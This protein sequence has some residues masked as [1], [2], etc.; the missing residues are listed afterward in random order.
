MNRMGSSGV[1][2]TAGLNYDDDRLMGPMGHTSACGLFPLPRPDALPKLKGY[3]RRSQHRAARRVRIR[4]DLREAIASLNWMHV[5]DFDAPPSAAHPLQREVLCRL[6]AL[7]ERADDLGDH[8]HLPSLEAAYGELLRGRDGYAE[9]STPASLAPYNLELVSLPTDLCDA[10]RAEELLEEADRRYLQG[11]ERMLREI[12]KEDSEVIKPYWDPALRHNPGR[13]RKFIQRLNDIKYLDFT[14]SPS[15]HAGVFFVWKSDGKRIRMI[16]DARPANAE[17]EEP[18]GISLP[19]A[20]TFAK[21]EMETHM[22][23][24]DDPELGI[25]AGLSDVRDCFHRIKQPR[26]L[27]KYFCF[28]PIEAKHVGLTGTVLE[29]H[30]LS[31]NDLV[32]PMPGSLCMG[33]SWSLFFAQRIN[34][35]VMRRVSSLSSSTLIHDRGGPAVFG[36]HL[37]DE[38]KHF[39]YVDNLGVM[40]TDR[41][42]VSGALDDL[43]GKFT[44]EKLLLHPG[45]IQHECIKALGVQLD[46]QNLFSSLSPDRYHRVRQ[47]LRCLL[48]RGRCSGRVLEILIGHCTYCG[49]MNRALLSVF[50]NVYKFIHS[51]HDHPATLW[52]SVRAELRAFCGLMPLIASDWCRPWN[53]LV[54][55]SDASEEGFGV[56]AAVWT[57]SQ[58]AAV[59]RVSERD[60]FK[61]AGSHSARETALTSAGFVKDE[62]SGK[63]AE[64]ILDDEEYLKLSGWDLRTDFPEVPAH[65][66][67]EGSWQTVRQGRWKKHE[68]IVHLEARALVKSFEYLVEDTHSKDCRQL[69]LVDSMSAALAFDRCRSR[70]F[71]MLRQIRKFCSYGLARNISFSVRWVASELNPADEP[72]RSP[73]HVVKRSDF[74]GLRPHALHHAD[75]KK[76]GAATARG[77]SKPKEKMCSAGER[78]CHASHEESQDLLAPADRPNS[79][80]AEE[81]VLLATQPRVFGQRHGQAPATA[82]ADGA[83]SREC[84]QFLEFRTCQGCQNQGTGEAKSRQAS[85]VCARGHGGK[86]H[87]SQLVRKESHWG[88][89]RQVLPRGVQAVAHFCQD[90]EADDDSP[91]RTGCNPC[92]VLQRPFHEGSP[93]ASGGQNHRH[94]DAPPVR[95]QQAGIQSAAA[96]LAMSQRLEALSARNLEESLSPRRV[97]CHRLG[98]EEAGTSSDG[99]LYAGGPLFVQPSFRTAEM[100]GLQPGEAVARDYRVLESFAE[101]RRK[102]GSVESRRVRRQHCPRLSLDEALG[103][104]P[105]EAAR[106]PGRRPPLVELQLLPLLQGFLPGDR[107]FGARHDTISD[108]AQRAFNRSLK[109]PA[110]SS[111]GPEKRKVAVAQKCGQI[112]EECSPGRNLPDASTTSPTS[113]PPRRKT[114]RGCDVGPGPRLASTYKSKGLKGQYVADLFAGKGGVAKA[115]R[116][117]GYRAKEWEL[118]RGPQFDLTKRSVLRQLRLDVQQGLILA[119]MLAPPCSSFSIA[120]DR[121][122]V[123]RT[124][125]HPWGLPDHMLSPTDQVKV[126]LGN[127]CF[128]SALKIIS[129]LD[130]QKIPWIL[131][132]PFTSKCW[133]LPPIRKLMQSNHV[134]TV[135]V[136]FC[137]YGTLWRKRTCLLCGNLDTQDVDR[138]RHLCK[139]RGLCSFSGKSHFQLTGSNHQGIPWTRIAQ[140][141]PTGLCRDLAFC[142]TSPT[143]Y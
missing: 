50:H 31:S 65:K 124:R 137:F 64:G 104:N 18:P 62:V 116:Q 126:Q 113:L 136:D 89:E 55:V 99:S 76:T 71:K 59:G 27:S 48:R 115:C 51:H 91:T 96:S 19:T 36:D 4:D 86:V 94:R 1:S 5:G 17:F 29:G 139:G 11:Q 125:D 106:Q 129:W 141:Y 95:V 69:F 138:L 123:I 37:P 83:R 131:E 120:R 90:A 54:P 75:L 101:S 56:C 15:Q 121:T 72:S 33:F 68:H 47:G 24:G 49:L 46:G 97:V 135:R 134:L 13:Y 45:E 9:P 107:D 39:V 53:E 16:V 42:A 114:A 70:N 98:I 66:L 43:V 93:S 67:R 78:K 41:Q 35:V 80:F 25:Y 7:V 109:K 6:E 103:S 110:V 2:L 28:L 88:P 23:D 32:F 133:F 22:H 38:L 14:L 140:P 34:E 82:E 58:A 10:P 87:G 117:L 74:F 105:A 92:G 30:T 79:F 122:A 21:I 57:S 102:D 40:S 142:L 52:N 20:E 8:G 3:G 118:S 108:E 61:R 81:A 119:A 84:R 60:R 44:Q 77:V 132:N 143:H 130:R 12:P 100:Q 85:E 73:L 63:W 128:R 111:R 112:R 26:W 127:Q